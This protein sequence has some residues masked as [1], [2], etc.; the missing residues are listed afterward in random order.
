[1]SEVGRQ[2]PADDLAVD[3]IRLDLS[4]VARLPRRPRRPWPSCSAAALGACS[5]RHGS[6]GW[7]ASSPSC[8]GRHSCTPAI[9]NH[10]V[11]NEQHST[12]FSL[13]T[14]EASVSARAPLSR[15]PAAPPAAV[16]KQSLTVGRRH[17]GRRVGREK[18]GQGVGAAASSSGPGQCPLSSSLPANKLPMGSVALDESLPGAAWR[19]LLAAALRRRVPETQGICPEDEVANSLRSRGPVSADTVRPFPPLRRPG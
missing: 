13:P 16:A 17:Y 10:R 14:N 3:D 2:Q 19:V 5:R 1:V 8:S 12:R 11:T 15:T 9:G 6:H 18:H 7:L 4:R